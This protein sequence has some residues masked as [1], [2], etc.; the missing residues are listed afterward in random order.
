[1]HKSFRSTG[2]CGS[3][4]SGTKLK[5]FRCFRSAELRSL[6]RSLR[7]CATSMWRHSS[8][9]GSSSPFLKG[10]R[11]RGLR[12]MAAN[13]LASSSTDLS[14]GERPGSFINYATVLRRRTSKRNTCVVC[15]CIAVPTVCVTISKDGTTRRNATALPTL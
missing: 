4:R 9:N 6:N 8:K 2:R 12:S 14:S 10:K 13:R 11:T 15:S 1:M 3:A 5:V 7:E